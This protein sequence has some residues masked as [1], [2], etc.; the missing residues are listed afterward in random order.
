MKVMIEIP[1]YSL[2]KN[3]PW[4]DSFKLVSF[5]RNL[6]FVD[7]NALFINT[8]TFTTDLNAF[9]IHSWTLPRTFKVLL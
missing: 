6:T 7:N 5:D 2:S 4:L 9:F 1:F 8:Y 3:V